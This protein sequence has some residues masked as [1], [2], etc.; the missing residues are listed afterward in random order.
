MD[1][2]CGGG[3]LAGFGTT[4]DIN[5]GGEDLGLGFRASLTLERAS[6]GESSISICTDLDCGMLGGGKGNHMVGAGEGVG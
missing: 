1:G 3:R 6:M 2:L 5:G 4:R